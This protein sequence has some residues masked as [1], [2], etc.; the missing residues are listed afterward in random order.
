[1]TDV[2]PFI[3][4]RYNSRL[5]EDMN[6]VISPWYEMIPAEQQKVYR[7]R[8]P[9]NI[10]NLIPAYEDDEDK[11]EEYEN[12]FSRTASVIQ[13]WRRDGI[14]VND[15]NKSF[16]LYEQTY[17]RSIAKCKVRRGVY[18]LINLNRQ[19]PTHMIVEGST[20]Y[21]GRAFHLKILR[22]TRCNFSPIPM[23]FHDP[24]GDFSKIFEEVQTSKP[25]EEIHETSGDTHR[26]WVINKKDPI[27]KMTDFFRNRKCY[28]VEGHKRYEVSLT[29]RDEQREATG[30]LD[31][32]QPF[33]YILVFLTSFEEQNVTT[34]PIHRVLSSEMGSGVDMQEFMEDLD[35]YFNINPIKVSLK[36][37]DAAAEKI[38]ST[39]AEK[40]KK[41]STI[42]MVL[43]DGRAFALSLKSDVDISDLY[44]EDSPLTD[45]VK[46]L[47]VS[48]L[49]HYIIR[50]CWIGNPELDLEES[51]ILYFEDAAA[52]L[53]HSLENKS[54]ATFLL[55]PCPMKSLTEVVAGGGEIPPF[56]VRLH[57]PIISGLI[58][59]DMSVRH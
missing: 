50:Q 38:L 47:D 28:M 44:D 20:P 32:Q 29:Y 39:I 19:K 22:A 53:K 23:F 5:I 18:A 14:L 11:Q 1:M 10:L 42:G 8:Y 13:A 2:F 55:N 54:A 7:E 56:S 37:P 16:Y 35:L 25:W 6:L 24:E 26:M 21:L 9:Y 4:T 52:A 48:I 58:V 57:P 3:G 59:R 36:K 31:G 45:A 12:S 34:L 41:N 46:K 51:D 17:A 30:K 43:P 15:N 33:D 27:S 40:G 49:N